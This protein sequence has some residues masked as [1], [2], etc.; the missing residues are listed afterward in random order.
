MPQ[1]DH[2]IICILVL[3]VIHTATK[4]F[5]YAE[6]VHILR[7]I[8]SLN[9]AQSGVGILCRFYQEDLPHHTFQKQ[10]SLKFSA[11]SPNILIFNV[12]VYF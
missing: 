6:T 2:M 9:C 4:L 3:V 1:R 5:I 10:T 8:K 11:E 12:K 7:L